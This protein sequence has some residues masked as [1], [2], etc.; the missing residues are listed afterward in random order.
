[1]VGFGAWR[2]A[3]TLVLWAPSLPISHPS[4]LADLA[5]PVGSSVRF[6]G[7][8]CKEFRYFLKKFLKWLYF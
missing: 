5:L 3:D 7:L 2:G 1:M 6:C 4:A 8:G